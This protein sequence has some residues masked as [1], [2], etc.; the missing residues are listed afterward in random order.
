[1]V[2]FLAAAIFAVVAALPFSKVLILVVVLVV[3]LGSLAWLLL[4]LWK[5]GVLAD[6]WSL[7]KEEQDRKA[8]RSELAP[9]DD[10]MLVCK[11]E[12][13]TYGFEETFAIDGLRSGKARP[14]PQETDGVGKQYRLEVH[15]LSDENGTLQIV[16]YVS[17]DQDPEVLSGEC[18]CDLYM[19]R[20]DKRSRWAAVPVDRIGRAESFPLHVDLRLRDEQEAPSWVP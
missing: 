7:H 11:M 13:G 12:R 19:R 8:H 15:R 14:K 3:A 9:V 18:S 4:L 20:D 10:E 6:R 1:V 2:G 16:G 5:K 17:P